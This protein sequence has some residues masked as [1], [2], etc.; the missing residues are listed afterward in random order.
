MSKGRLLVSSYRAIILVAVCC[1]A[2]SSGLAAECQGHDL[3]PAHKSEAPAAYA[4]IKAAASGMPF[5]RGKLFRLSRAG[6]EFSYVFATLHSSDQRITSLSPRLRAA[7]TNAKIVAVE[8]VETGAVLR[9]AVVNDRDAWRRAII[10]RENQRAD[11]L[12]DKTDFARLEDFAARLDM[13]KSAAHKFKPST[14]ALLLDLPP[15]AIRLP[16]AKFDALL[17]DIARQNK[18]E[19]VGLETTIEQLE[20]LDGLPRKTERDLLISVMRQADRWE[21]VTETEIARYTEGDIG[22]LLA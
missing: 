17:A 3:F 16:G 10:A 19:T 14:L 11:R 2:K 12:L 7:L 20:A 22:G 6:T 13:P 1:L 9:Q 8:T 18:I 21:D 5:K 4:A 15:C